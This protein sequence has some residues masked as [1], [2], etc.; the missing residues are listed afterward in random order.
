MKEAEQKSIVIY[1]SWK[2]PL[3]RLSLEQKGR[4][5]DALLDFPES[6]EFEDQ[7]LVMAWDFMSEA[8]ESNAQ[9]WGETREKRAAAGRKGAE[10]TNGKRQQNTANPANADFAEQKQQSAANAAVS[11]NDNV[12][13]SVNGNVSATDYVI[14]SSSKDDS[15]GTTTTPIE[16]EFR[17]CICDRPS[18]TACRELAA[19]ADRL[20][21]ELVRAVIHKCADLG[22]R[23]WAYVRKALAEAETQ[24]CTS[25]EEYMK[26]N[27][28][29]GSR[30]K[31]TRVDRAE[32][33]G[34]EW[35]AQSTQRRPFRKRGDQTEGDE[36]NA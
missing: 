33:S 10:S 13:V 12:S 31:G 36:R 30:A 14:S 2:K 34:N 3:R 20:G 16:E 6:P 15:Y 22:A 7:M 4:I 28:I 17:A 32:P 23:S 18:E 9:K 21:D 8:L 35:L 11:V 5:F 29:G 27:P 24:G 25:A 1:K 26:T 19:Y